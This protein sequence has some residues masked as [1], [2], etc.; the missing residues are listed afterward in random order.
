MVPVF[1]CPDLGG[2]AIGAALGGDRVWVTGRSGDW[3]IIRLTDGTG[4]PAW[5]PL[6]D[7]Q[8][9]GDVAALP[10]VECTPPEAVP[11][12]TSTSAAGT[13]PGA[14]TSTLATTTSSSTSTIS[15]TSTTAPGS[16]TV[17]PTT[18]PPTTPPTTAPDGQPPVISV[19]PGQSSFYDVNGDPGCVDQLLVSVSASDPSGATVTG[20]VARWTGQAGPAEVAL[21]ASGGQWRLE[22]FSNPPAV[23]ATVTLTATAVDGRGNS[24][25]GTA[26][27]TLLNAASNGCVV[28]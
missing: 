1:D 21:V 19:S 20:V 3:A 25:T 16:T 13:E 8:I 17:A 26:Q 12:A 27:V 14:T 15:T 9:D 22:V 23:S 28:G 11:S 10:E 2:A 5:I 6:A 18:N 4:R 7:V 24:G